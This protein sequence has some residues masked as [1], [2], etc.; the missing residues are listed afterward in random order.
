MI[1]GLLGMAFMVL[2]S[3]YLVYDYYCT[4]ILP[5]RALNLLIHG[6]DKDVA[7]DH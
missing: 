3:C 2:F 1:I 6:E 5:R 7:E 4:E